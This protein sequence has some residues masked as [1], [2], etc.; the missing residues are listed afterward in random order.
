M[1][2][3]HFKIAVRT[4]LRQKGYSL[5]N[6]AGLAVGLACAFL[7]T[8]WI[9]DELRYDRFHESGDRLYRVMRHVY[10]GDEIRTSSSVTF[11]I[12][13]ALEEAYP[14]V[15]DVTVV[16]E[17]VTLVMNRG[18]IP[19]LE[20]GLYA[21]PH[22]FEM[23]TWNLIEGNPAEVLRDPASIV[24]STSLAE[25]YFGLDWRQHAIGGTIS[26]PVYDLGDFTVTGVFEDVPTNSSLQ[27]D[28]VLPIELFVRQNEW[29]HNWM[30]SGIRI[31]VR[32]HEGSDGAALSENITDIQNE[33]IEGF[34]SDLFL[35]SYVDQRLYSNFR[36]GVLV[37]GLIDYLRI[38][39]VVAL[40]IVLIASI[41]FM[42]LSTARSMR[43]AREI[44]VRKAIGAGRKS[45]ASQ[46]LGESALLVFV[47]FIL[48][49]GLVLA[50]LPAFNG[51]TE[52]EIAIADLGGGTLL[53]FAGIAVLTALIAGSYPALYLSSFDPVGIL[54]G[55][56]RLSGGSARL[57][58]GLVVFQF[59]MSIL[60]I[61]G[62]ITVYR[63]IDYIHSKNLGLDRE[64]VVSIFM[65][66]EMPE[67]YDTVKEELLR[68]P[69]IAHVTSTSTVPLDVGGNT[70]SVLWRGK[71]PDAQISMNIITANFDFL[72]VMRIE[73][74]AGRDFDPAFGTDSV[75]YIINERALE[76][77]GFESP[78]GERL[79][80][81][82]DSGS[83]V[84][85]V[86]D[87]HMASMYH[88]IEPTIIRLRPQQALNLYARTEPGQTSQALA[89]LKAVYERFA[90]GHPFEPQFLDEHFRRMYRSETVIGTL[91]GVFTAIALFIAC[92]GL[93]GLASFT[94]QQRT[95]EI[96]V[97]K[98]LGATVTGLASLLSRDFVALVL[99]AFVLSAPLAY[100][101][102]H[103]WLD[104]FAYRTE[105]GLGIFLLTGALV[106]LIALAT[107]SYQSI[108]AALADPVRSLR[109]E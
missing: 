20:W 49:V 33:H 27:F 89:S 85:V 16:T 30:N 15:E 36:D 82:G 55:T 65:H 86:R 14:E 44:G 103:E 69:G 70:H 102:A 32:T 17:R 59:A 2:R 23:F 75:N 56:F 84:G 62:T 37:G 77:M 34:R 46:F 79:S 25:R 47:A 45:L 52:K 10:S 109:Y 7:I 88:E 98:V 71:N 67:Q 8:I 72:D 91:A 3:N 90:P 105:I 95:K 66:G 11:N 63:Q 40:M 78:L 38:F 22:F 97:R 53:L 74:V 60:L 108:R 1:L 51:L 73:L 4:L 101:F 92:L 96:G 12:A 100:V 57:R 19:I 24:I 43:R 9:Q 5:L 39:S 50:F 29:L 41:N 6:V 81:W 61:V 76:V 28:F 26:D 104:S 106:V 54:R 94:A 107:V 21:G 64:N 35:Q 80:F 13:R 68:R 83:I 93:F 42:N 31:F 99:I 58:R 18:D 48:A 87:F